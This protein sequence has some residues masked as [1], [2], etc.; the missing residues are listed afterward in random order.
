MSCKVFSI[1]IFDI[2]IAIKSQL[3]YLNFKLQRWLCGHLN[4]VQDACRPQW[5]YL[6]VTEPA[7]SSVKP[8]LTSLSFPLWTRWWQEKSTNECLHAVWHR[9]TDAIIL[10][11]QFLWFAMPFTQRYFPFSRIWVLQCFD[12]AIKTKVEGYS[13][14]VKVCNK[15]YFKAL[16]IAFSSSSITFFPFISEKC[17]W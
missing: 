1:N 12:V 15:S 3:L 4:F 7:H 8:S 16:D 5:N 13:E 10:E 6:D 9:F 17:C 11:N 14:K 2:V